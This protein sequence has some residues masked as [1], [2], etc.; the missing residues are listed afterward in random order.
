MTHEKMIRVLTSLCAFTVMIPGL[1]AVLSWVL[2]QINRFPATQTALKKL[3]SNRFY[4]SGNKSEKHRT[5]GVRIVGQ[6]KKRN[7]SAKVRDSPHLR[8]DLRLFFLNNHCF[9][10]PQQWLF[11][12][13]FVWCVIIFYNPINVS[14]NFWAPVHI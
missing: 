3:K 8:L 4:F 11:S 5:S 6:Q 13:I 2:D 9:A 12:Y 1:C 7:K 14:T 10:I